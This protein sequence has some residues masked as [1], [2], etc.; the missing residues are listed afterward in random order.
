MTDQPTETEI[1]AAIRK[2]GYLM[3]QEVASALEALGFHVQTNRAFEDVDEGK[4]RELDVAAVSGV[5]SDDTNKVAVF[6][7]LLC[8]CKNST[9][10]FVFLLR[11]R[12]EADNHRNV[13]EILLP[14]TVFHV[15][16]EGRPNTMQSMAAI[17]YLG[18][19]G[20]RHQTNEKL[21]AVQFAKIVRDKSQWVANHA[22]LY[23]AIFYPLVKALLARRREISGRKGDWRYVWLFSPVVVTSGSLY[24]LDTTVQAPVPAQVDNVSFTRHIKDG[25]I[26]GHFTIEFVTQKWLCDYVTSRV[27][28]FG[29][30]VASLVKRSPENFRKE[31]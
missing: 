15:P 31:R 7:E 3:E 8:E 25:Q 26:D 2:S 19:R 24:V 28:P 20:L 9:N 10:P 5:H 16:I 29:E 11:P 1:L 27:A 21:K 14:R 12:T 13:E 30:N 6:V 22:G 17:D 23:D 18:I 4:S